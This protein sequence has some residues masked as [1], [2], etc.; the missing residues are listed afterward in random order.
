M[1][2]EKIALSWNIYNISAWIMTNHYEL[3]E[4]LIF[5]NF[6]R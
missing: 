5:M 3:L 1:D 4:H 6:N 2:K